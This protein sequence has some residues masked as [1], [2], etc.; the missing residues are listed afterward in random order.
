[1]EQNSK[2][3]ELRLERGL[4]QEQ[5]AAKASMSGPYLSQIERGIRRLNETQIDR[6]ADALGVHRSV[7]L[8]GSP[9]SIG[10]DPAAEFAALNETL[11][12]LTPEDRQRVEAFAAALLRSQQE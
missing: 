7:I 2:I 12:H 3:R 4:T 5:L 1:M 10:P 9:P 8:G 11:A 6:L